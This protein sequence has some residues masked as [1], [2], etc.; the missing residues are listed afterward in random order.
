MLGVISLLKNQENLLANAV[1]LNSQIESASSRFLLAIVGSALV[2]HG[3]SRFPVKLKPISLIK[4]RVLR[5]VFTNSNCMPFKEL[6][7]SLARSVGKGLLITIWSIN[8][9]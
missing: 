9:D 4:S 6:C 3:Q 2:L 5:Q 1:L 8:D 7:K